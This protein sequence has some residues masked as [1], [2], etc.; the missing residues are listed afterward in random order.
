VSA[1]AVPLLTEERRE[2]RAAVVLLTGVRVRLGAGPILFCGIVFGSAKEVLIAGKR[3]K[4]VMK[5]QKMTDIVRNE[6]KL[7]TV[8]TNKNWVKG[9]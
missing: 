4:L 8:E 9:I 7:N 3:G 6:T 2:V 1:A 5:W